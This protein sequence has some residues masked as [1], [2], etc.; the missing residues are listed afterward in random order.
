MLSAAIKLQDRLLRHFTLRKDVEDFS[1]QYS[2]ESHS[3]TI[4]S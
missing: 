1:T 4:A 3:K 2:A